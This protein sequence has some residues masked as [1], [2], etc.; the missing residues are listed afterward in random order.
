SGA[1]PVTDIQN[2]RDAIY[3]LSGR[4][5]A[6]CLIGSNR[7]SH[8]P[9][10]LY[11]KRIEAARWFAEHSKMPF[12]V[13]GTPFALPNYRGACPVSQK[14]SM[15]KQYRF[16]LCFENT[17]DPILSAG[18]V[19]EKILD[20]MESR[21]IPIY[22]GA[23]NIEQYVP[24]D[25]FIDF[26]KFDGYADLEQYLQKMTD[27]KYQQYIDAI[28]AWVTGGNLMKFSET[29]LYNELAM[30][31]AEASGIDSEILFGGAKSWTLSKP[32]PPTVR[33]WQFV[34]SP[35]MWTWKHLATAN[36]PLLENGKIVNRLQTTLSQYTEPGIQ[37]ED[38]SALIRKKPSIRVLAAGAKFFSGNARQGYDYGWWNMFDALRRFEN[39]ETKFF[40]YSTESKVRGVAGMSEW[41]EEIIYKEKPDI[42]FY[43]P[44]NGIPGILPASLNSITNS[45]DTQ[46][47]IWMNHLLALSDEDAKLWTSCADHIITTS[48]QS[49]RKYQEAGFGNKIIKSQWA[50]NPYT[51]PAKTCSKYREISFIGS[52]ESNRSEMIDTIRQSGL[53][54]DVFGSGWHED[55]YL[56][57]YDMLKI[58]GQSKINLD[59]QHIDAVSPGQMTRRVFEIAGCRS[60]VIT[61]SAGSPDE[62]YEPDKEVVCAASPEELIDK[63]RFYLAH[64]T[65]R[66][67]IA[68]RG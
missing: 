50:F 3:P 49:F 26:R 46:T 5:N 53:P 7:S 33:Q 12:D 30:L 14:L 32:V 44:L 60:F 39:V 66:E 2:I 16:N 9:Y 41:L 63:C 15:M 21:T 11:S 1:N 52:F 57:F 36:P 55:S 28:D 43:Y 65:E 17:N 67:A 6:I 59:L 48:N 29:L 18:Y 23:S 54:I 64:E 42:L 4:K 10:E 61:N 22:L 68:L 58:F 20:C 45:T 47:I 24:G 27:E 37:R 38:K 19:T 13:Y 35:A 51:Y 8:V 40:D 25:C 62:Y 34:Q 31:C 56:S